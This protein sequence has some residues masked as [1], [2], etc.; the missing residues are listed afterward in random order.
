MNRSSMVPQT[1]LSLTLLEQSRSY[2]EVASLVCGQWSSE[3]QL[4]L[5]M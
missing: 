3:I 4:L 1:P 2:F 5:L